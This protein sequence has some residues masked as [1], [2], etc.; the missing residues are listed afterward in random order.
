MNIIQK[1]LKENN[2]TALILMNRLKMWTYQTFVSGRSW[3]VSHIYNE[4]PA[5]SAPER[6][7]SWGSKTWWKTIKTINS[8][9]N[10]CNMYFL[11]KVYTVYN[12]VWGKAADAGEFS[13][14][15]VLKVT[16]QSVRLLL[17]VSYRKNGGTGCTSC[18]PIILLHGGAPLVPAPMPSCCWESQSYIGTYDT[19]INH[20][21]NNKTFPCS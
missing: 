4:K 8:K 1:R 16:L 15:F 12:G 9:Y 3:N 18:S 6:I 17:T 19:L 10:L 7:I 5:A 20:H 21:L 2:I 11:T 14:I 13:R